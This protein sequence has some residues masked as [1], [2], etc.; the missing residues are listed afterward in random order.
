[1]ARFEVGGGSD[2]AREKERNASGSAKNT[3]AS[4]RYNKEQFYSDGL[5]EMAHEDRN[6]EFVCK[7]HL[8]SRREE[9]DKC[10]GLVDDTLDDLTLDQVAS[11]TLPIVVGEVRDQ[12]K[13]TVETK[14]T[15]LVRR[16]YV[17][18]SLDDLSYS[19][20]SSSESDKEKERERE[21]QRLEGNLTW[22]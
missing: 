14:S 8:S 15:S 7:T 9:E 18:T 2:L 12:A 6:Q 19:S 10:R 11:E 22:T 21:N 5:V 4:E 16:A 13:Q 17:E 3:G 20:N 1:M